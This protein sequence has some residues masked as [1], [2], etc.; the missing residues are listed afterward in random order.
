MMYFLELLTGSLI[1][2]LIGIYLG[3][4]IVEYRKS[5]RARPLSSVPRVGAQAAAYEFSPRALR[6]GGTE[7]G[8]SESGDATTDGGK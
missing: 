8:L 4:K 6:L 1:G 2:N 5:K 7:G 3:N